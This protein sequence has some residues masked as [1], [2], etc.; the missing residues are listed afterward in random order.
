MA[1]R[2]R[3]YRAGGVDQVQ[4]QTG[5]DL[6]ALRGL[7]QKLWVALSCPV[8]GLEFD[9][10]TLALI[11]GDDDGKVHATDLLAAIEW[12]AGVLVDVEE[13]ARP[14]EPL[15][16]DAV[17]DSTD[18]GRLIRDTMRSLLGGLGKADAEAMSVEET[19]KALDTFNHL[20]ENGDG[21]VPASAATDEDVRTLVAAILSGIAEPRLDR[22]GDPG[23]AA[24][25][26]ASFFEALERRRSW[27]KQ[28]EAPELQLLGAATA[29]AHSA[30]RAVQTKIEDYF[31]RCQIVA[32][33]DRAGSAMNGHEAPFA[34]LGGSIIGR[35]VTE[36]EG[37]P[38]A[39]VTPASSLPLGHAAGSGSSVGGVNP[40]WAERMAAF[41]DK[42]VAPLLGARTHLT[43]NEFREIEA[44]FAARSSWHQQQPVTPWDAL[45]LE[46]AEPWLVGNVRERLDALVTADQAATARAG[47]IESVEKLVR[48]K[49][50]LLR[51]ANNFVAFREFYRPGGRAIFQIGTLYL[52]QRALG[53]CLRVN[54]GPRHVAM[55]PLASTYLVYCDVK[56][57][58]GQ[59]MQIVGAVTNGDVDNLM[60][61]RN[62][63]FY[64]LGGGDWDATV[65]RIVENPISIRQAFW[66]P[67][68]K[69]V[70]LI[71]E[72][73]SK[74]AA[75]A[76]AE[77]DAKI[78]SQA[79]E[80]DAATKGDV[81][82]AATPPKKIDIGVVAALGVAVGGIT[83]ALGVFMQAFLGLGL[84][85]PL[86][87]LG[88][89]L[90]ISGPA[91]AVA[92][93][94]LRRRN[95]GPLLDANGWAINVMPRVNVALG[96][97]LTQLATLPAG[98]PRDLVDPFA[99][100]K[101][102]LWRTI[103]A[104]LFIAVLV[105]WVLGTLDRYLPTKFQSTTLL[106]EAA[107]ARVKVQVPPPAPA[108]PAP[109]VSKP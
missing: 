17:K 98:T 23:V 14:D 46:A 53:L 76:Q 13:L 28:G 104:L 29:E 26:V 66:S 32:F 39:H 80:V 49:Q 33:D 87:I 1:H 97:S 20:S 37:F 43:E 41:R 89:I 42:V 88:L 36:L 2:F 75:A 35:A 109:A 72:Q 86:G 12:A 55:G 22:S 61:G 63:L 84:W 78:G 91:M 51:L 77:A 69:L 7:D 38:L 52:D 95:I 31:A 9:S 21:L 73:V 56:N 11:D 34:A 107:P 96:R 59:A 19:V 94:K 5:A 62:G 79:L 103:L 83:A 101:P 71:E 108:P 106:G 25:D 82:P 4:L 54:D 81:K 92:W 44:R 10:R 93:L 40:A 27:Q 50:G 68:K 100:K 18:E 58:Q 70:R 24:E 48:L 57:S 15:R 60:V 102:P 99:E 3:F 90:V 8:M 65:V 85:M 30:F 74:R 67:Y 16:L 6:L 64:D 47:A 105:G 45:T